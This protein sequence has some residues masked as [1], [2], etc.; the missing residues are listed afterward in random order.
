MLDWL[1]NVILLKKKKLDNFVFAGKHKNTPS[2][3]LL[4]LHY[5]FYSQAIHLWYRSNIHF[6]LTA[7]YF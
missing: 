7:A 6:L 1:I 2:S 5:H 3:L 4:N